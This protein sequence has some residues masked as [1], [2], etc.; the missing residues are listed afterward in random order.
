MY[1]VATAEPP[2]VRKVTVF[3]TTV[4][5]SIAVRTTRKP[6]ESLPVS[7]SADVRES[8]AQ[9]VAGLL[10]APP[11]ITLKLSSPGVTFGPV[12]GIPLVIEL[13]GAKTSK[14]HSATF[15]SKSQR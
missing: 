10:Y 11:L 5:S 12:L 2:F 15:P 3:V 9:S 14:H 7:E 8:L 1:W 4:N 6:I 13:F